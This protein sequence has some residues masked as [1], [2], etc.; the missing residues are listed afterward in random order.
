MAGIHEKEMPVPEKREKKRMKTVTL[1]FSCWQFLSLVKQNK[2][3][4]KT[5]HVWME[6]K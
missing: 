5:K 6:Y 2:K 1:P 3:N 4:S